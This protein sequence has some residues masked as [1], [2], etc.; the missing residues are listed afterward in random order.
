MTRRPLN[1]AQR[2]VIVVALGLGAFFFG[3]WLIETWEFGS[4]PFTGW[5]GYAPLS[6]STFTQTRI[7]NPWVI[8]LVWLVLITAWTFASLVILRRDDRAV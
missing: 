4:R 8:L 5:V 7:L 1:Q 2:V 6:N 3:Q